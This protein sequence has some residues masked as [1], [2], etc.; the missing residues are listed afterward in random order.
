MRLPLLLL[1]L[2]LLLFAGQ[3]ARAQFLTAEDFF[4]SGAHFYISNNIPLAKERVQMG[5]Q[6]Y[7]NDD[8]L[9]KLE[10]LLN[11]QQQQQQQSQNSQSQQNQSQQ[12]QQKQQQQKQQQQQ[13]DQAQSK[14]DSQAQKEKEKQEQAKKEAEQ[15]KEQEKQAQAAQQKSGDETNEV[16]DANGAHAMTPKE[17]ERLLDAQKDNEEFLTMKPKAKPEDSIHPVKDW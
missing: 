8:K 13:S 16:A 17:A 1:S 7:P 9:K 4:N 6:I 14:Q 2:S 5:R 10:Q 15:K 12:D 3:P 11:Q